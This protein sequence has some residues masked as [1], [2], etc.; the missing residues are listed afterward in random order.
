MLISVCLY[1]NA[2]CG[3]TNDTALNSSDSVIVFTLIIQTTAAVRTMYCTVSQKNETTVATYM[4]KSVSNFSDTRALSRKG[5]Y[6]ENGAVN[7]TLA[8]GL[9]ISR[10]VFWGQFT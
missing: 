8:I 4:E 10:S 6:R 9:T 2:R 5:E 7:Y 1:N 3:Y